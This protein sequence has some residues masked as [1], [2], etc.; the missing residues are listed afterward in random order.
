[1]RT[2]LIFLFAA[3]A[4]IAGGVWAGDS[5]SGGFS[6]TG[7]T[8]LFPSG[9]GGYDRAAPVGGGGFDV[10]AANDGADT[11]IAAPAPR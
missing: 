2:V 4:G 7:Y 3:L 5:G 6:A 11:V 8:S 10:Q 1:V 9:G